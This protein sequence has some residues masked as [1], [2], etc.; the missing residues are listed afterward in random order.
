MGTGGCEGGAME[1]AFEFAFAHGL[2]T[3]EQ[4]PYNGVTGNCPYRTTQ[5]GH[6]LRGSNHQTLSVSDKPLIMN[7]NN[8]GMLGFVKLPENKYDPVMRALIEQGPVGVSVA[9]DGWHEY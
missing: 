9:A 7:S 4:W 6:Q 5:G 2:R 3:E 8:F 1:L